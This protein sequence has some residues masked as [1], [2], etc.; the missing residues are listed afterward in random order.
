MSWASVQAYVQLHIDTL[1]RVVIHK[2]GVIERSEL[3]MSLRDIAWG[4][5]IIQF[6]LLIAIMTIG[7]PGTY[8]YANGFMYISDNFC[9]KKLLSILFML[10]TLPTWA[11]LACS[12]SLETS[13]FARTSLLL[14]MSIPLPA[15]IGIVLFSLCETPS[16]HYVYVNLFVGTIAFIHITVAYTASHFK[17]IQYYSVVVFGTTICGIIFLCLAIVTTGTGM[18]R[19]VAVIMEYL[20]VIGFIIL[21]ALSVDRIEEH[22][23]IP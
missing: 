21:N 22:I 4:T 17:F 6:I 5:S 7:S 23:T 2:G 20:A 16:L 18:R 11:L 14:L 1:K 15:G 19:D 9:T 12:I 13:K 8:T 3:L 10:S